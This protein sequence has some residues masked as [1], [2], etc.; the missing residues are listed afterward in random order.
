MLFENFFF[1]AGSLLSTTAIHQV[2]AMFKHC[3]QQLVGR[4]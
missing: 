3:R 4:A 2:T 1:H